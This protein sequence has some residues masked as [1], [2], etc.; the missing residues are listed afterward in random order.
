MDAKRGNR[1]RFSSMSGWAAP[2]TYTGTTD[3]GLPIAL[4]VSKNAVT[5]VRFGWRARC[6]DGQVHTN[7]IALGGG[8]IRHGA[9]RVGGTLETGGV[10]HVAGS[11]NGPTA[12]GHLSRS[13][14]S[15]FGTNCRATGIT[16][17]ARLQGDGAPAA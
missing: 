5:G 1:Q 15:A 7:S 4:V 16:W 12:S 9:F 14:G 13:E 17:R 8:P 11:V 3:Q 2:R 6:Q 10:A